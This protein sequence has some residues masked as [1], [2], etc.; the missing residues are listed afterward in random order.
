MQP[1]RGSD[2]RP[3]PPDRREHGGVSW[4][5]HTAMRRRSFQTKTLYRSCLLRCFFKLSFVHLCSHVCIVETVYLCHSYKHVLFLVRYS[6]CKPHCCGEVLVG[7]N[8]PH[9][10]MMH[11]S[12]PDSY[13]HLAKLNLNITTSKVIH[14]Q[15]LYYHL[16]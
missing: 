11:C 4:G 14:K 7:C 16:K 2:G 12:P 5:V 13:S 15:L 6:C 9:I 1:G 8:F 10:P 3:H